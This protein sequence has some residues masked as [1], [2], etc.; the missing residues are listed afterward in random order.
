MSLYKHYISR[1]FPT[2][3]SLTYLAKKVN[4]KKELTAILVR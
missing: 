1:V 2:F 3:Y 4:E